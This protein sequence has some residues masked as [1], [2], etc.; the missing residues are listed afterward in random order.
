MKDQKISFF[1]FFVFLNWFSLGL[2]FLLF[3]SYFCHNLTSFTQD[4]GRHLKVGEII[5][6]QKKIPKTNLF[7]F[8]F[9]QFPFINHHWLAEVIFFLINK[10]L[11]LNSLIFLK[12][13]FTSLAFF[14]LLIFIGKRFSWIVSLGW[15][16]VIFFLFKQ[17]TEVRPEI[18]SYFF[19]SIYLIV[20]SNLRSFKK[21]FFLLPLIQVFWINTHIY[22]F[23]GPTLLFLFF[24]NHL[25]FSKLKKKK[26]LIKIFGVLVLTSLACFFNPNFIK[27]ALYPLFVFKNYGYR[28]VENQSFFFM[29]RYFDKIYDP[30]FLLIFLISLISFLITLNNQSFYKITSFLFFSFLGFQAIRN[31]PVFAL[32][33]FILV[34]QNL[35]LIKEKFI[36]KLNSESISNF[37]L[38]FYFIFIPLVLFLSYQS[39]SNQVYL[40]RFRNKRFGLGKVKGAEAGVD[41]VLKNKI[42]G[43]VFNNFDI[44]SFLIYRLYPQ[45]KVFVDGR[46]EAYPATFFKQTYIP[47]QEKKEKWQ[48]IDQQYNFNFIFFS[49]TDITPWATQFLKRISTN[50]QWQLVFLDDYVIIFLKK[51][52]LNSQIIEKSSFNEN[53]F[54]FS[55]Q[56]QIDCYARIKRILNILGW[57]EKGLS[58]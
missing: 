38:L 27:G 12:I 33:V 39:I 35:F 20:L 19:L 40:K 23:I 47:M 41:F 34:S 58:L 45:E 1:K 52:N 4:L 8:T 6:Q 42:S 55:C 44:G 13:V 46:P 26:E 17:R 29:S 56:K 21:Y 51:N 9:S 11:S 43:P 32:A 31:I 57:Q 22:F 3:F 25:I 54:H 16:L 7:S 50:N 14:S 53:N 48:Q 15:G 36:S 28:V 49:H 24:L 2:I 18:F 37:K 30:Y 5:I 10:Y